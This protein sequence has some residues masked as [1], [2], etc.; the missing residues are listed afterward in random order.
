MRRYISDFFSHGG[1]TYNVK[2]AMNN[3]DFTLKAG[4]I[5]Y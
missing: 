5:I 4:C 3:L 2:T 1:C